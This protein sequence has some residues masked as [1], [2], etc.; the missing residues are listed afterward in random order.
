[1]PYGQAG[2]ESASSPRLRRFWAAADHHQR[3][4]GN[5]LART[6]A[7]LGAMFALVLAAHA[8]ATAS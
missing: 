7:Y 5:L 8:L 6:L 2:H 4:L 3:D 1:M